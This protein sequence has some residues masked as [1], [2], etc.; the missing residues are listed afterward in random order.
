MATY[1]NGISALQLQ[2]QLAFASYKTAW[3]LCAK[4]RRSMLVPD[5]CP[6]LPARR[7]RRGR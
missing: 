2:R 6:P 1:S 4:L 3:L 7:P 5:R